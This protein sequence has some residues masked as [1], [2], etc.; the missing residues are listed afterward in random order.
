M[1]ITQSEGLFVSEIVQLIY[2]L[3]GLLCSREKETRI[4]SARETNTFAVTQN[5]LTSLIITIIVFTGT[6]R[7]LSAAVRG[8]LAQL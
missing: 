5:V 6:L 1:S 4:D 3:C 2:L 7:E 8:A